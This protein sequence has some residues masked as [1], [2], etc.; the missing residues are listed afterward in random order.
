MLRS[1]AF[2]FTL[3]TT[4]LGALAACSGTLGPT[5]EQDDPNP[6]DPTSPRGTDAGGLVPGSDG[7]P[8]PTTDGGVDDGGDDDGGNNGGSRRCNALRA[9]VERLRP[10]AAACAPDEKDVCGELIK[11]VCCPLTVTDATSNEAI[12]F[13]QAVESFTKAE[14]LAFCP[15]VLCPTEPSRV[16]VAA[17]VG[18]EKPRCR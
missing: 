2:F 10:A 6:G 14:C 15:K 5:I 1:T 17:S 8:P 12:A 4:T 18:Q 11:D 7:G 3:A 9:E 16:C 13:T